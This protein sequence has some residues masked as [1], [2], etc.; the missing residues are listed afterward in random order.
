MIH[1][2][3]DVTISAPAIKSI[4]EL[5]GNHVAI[6]TIVLRDFLLHVTAHDF[7]FVGQ[8]V[9]TERMLGVEGDAECSVDAIVAGEIP[10][11]CLMTA[12]LTLH[13][14]PA[15]VGVCAE[16]PTPQ[17]GLQRAA[18]IKRGVGMGVVLSIV[19]ESVDAAIEGCRKLFRDDIPL[20]VA[21][22]IE[23]VALVVSIGSAFVRRVS[24]IQA[25]LMALAAPSVCLR[26]I[27]VSVLSDV[28]LQVAVGVDAI[29]ALQL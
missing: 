22:D 9:L 7:C 18:S 29:V 23:K 26:L 21:V 24:A 17:V 25:G 27:E 2:A 6:V 20:V 14:V 28:F 11:W 3:L 13:E 15:V 1:A 8:G 16:R 12:M 10:R 4:R 19:E 5:E